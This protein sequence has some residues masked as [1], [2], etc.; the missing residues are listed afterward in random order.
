MKILSSS[1]KAAGII[2]KT[3]CYNKGS[4]ALLMLIAIVSFIF[5]FDVSSWSLSEDFPLDLQ[6][7]EKW[8]K[9]ITIL[10]FVVAG[11]IGWQGYIRRWEDS[12]PNKVT[13]H[14]MFNGDYI[15]SCYRAYL[16][17]E[18]DI[19]NW[20]QQIGRQMTGSNLGMAPVITQKAL[21]IID[22]PEFKHYETTFFLHKEPNIFNNEK[23]KN[24]YL[25]WVVE[26]DSVNKRIHARIKH[27][28]SLEQAKTAGEEFIADVNEKDNNEKTPT[29]E[30]KKV[31]FYYS[32]D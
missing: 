32:E 24:K 22:D 23:L 8:N 21:E 3:L 28:L 5:I 10:T 19:R 29:T 27:P 25:T 15:M 18:D 17:G 13:V 16:A 1:R 6:N 12:L 11:V 31:I 7:W 14:F 30:A 20:A 9:W 26:D 4:V 2:Y